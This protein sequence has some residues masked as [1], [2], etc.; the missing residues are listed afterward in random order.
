MPKNIPLAG[1]RILLAEDNSIQALDLTLALKKARAE[2]VGP[3]KTL[4]EFLALTKTANLTCA[5]LDVMLGHEYVFPAARVL[6]EQGTPIVFYTGTFVECIRR[7]WPDAQVVAKPASP[8]L[9]VEAIRLVCA[10][11]AKV[12]QVSQPQARQ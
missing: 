8:E 5:V 9:L 7:D 4:T 1:A 11:R 2:V 10:R 12:T 6:K 3:A